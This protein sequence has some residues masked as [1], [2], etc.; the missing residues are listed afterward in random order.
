[1]ILSQF[2]AHEWFTRIWVIQEIT[3]SQH[4]IIR[5]GECEIQWDVVATTAIWLN[6]L[7]AYEIV[8][9]VLKDCLASIRHTIQMHSIQGTRSKLFSLLYYTRSFDAADPR[10]KVSL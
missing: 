3:L 4:P 1:M 2:Y 9:N 5:Y 7:G 10:D 8:Q 6:N